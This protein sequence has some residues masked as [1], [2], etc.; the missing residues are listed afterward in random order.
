MIELLQ[1]FLVLWFCHALADF[2]LQSNAMSNGK[3]KKA[4]LKNWLKLGRDE[5]DFDKRVWI[6]W[7][8]AHA[9]I[10]G[11]VIFLVFGNYWIFV[12]EVITH[13]TIDYLKCRD[14]TN[15]H[16]DQGLHIGLRVVYA[17]LIVGGI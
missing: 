3:N 14:I 5:K 12:I 16:Q 15:I 17:F 1:T 7:M 8:S 11:G 2:S 4:G 6:Y 13:F 9:L 10:Q